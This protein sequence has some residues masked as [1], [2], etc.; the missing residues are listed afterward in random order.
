MKSNIIRITIVLLATLFLAGCNDFLKTSPTDRV[1]DQLVWQNTKYADL[2]I[3]NFYAYF[4]RYGVFG[5]DQFSGNMTEGLTNTLKYGS[6]QPGSK[7]GDSNNYVFYPERISTSQ[8]LLDVW[9]STYERIRRINEFLESMYRL[10]N[11]TVEQKT[12]YEAQA[13]FFRAYCYF[14]LAKRHGG[15]ILYTDINFQK[16]KNRSSAE[17]TWNLISSDLDFAADNLP[18]EWDAQNAGRLTKTMV[19][20]FKSR[21]M[22]Y[23]ERW[24]DAK[25]AADKV[26]SSGKYSLEAEYADAWKGSNAEAIIQVLYNQVSGPNHIFDKSYCP[27][28]DYLASGADENGGCAGP[29]QEMVEAYEAADGSVVDWSPWHQKTT[30]TPPYDQLEPRFHATVLYNGATWKGAVMDITPTGEHGRYMDYRADNYAKGRT[31]TGYYL[32]KLMDE[33]KKNVVQYPSQQTWVELR[34]AEVY[35][36][37]AEAEFRL[38]NNGA[39]LADLN[40]IRARVNL[41]ARTGI[42]GDALFNAIRHERM[43]ELAYE[44]HLFWDMRRWRLADK[45]YNNYRVHGL[46]ITGTAPDYTYEYVDAD[47]QD[48]KFLA[49]TYVFP[50]PDSEITTNTG[51]EQYDEWK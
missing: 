2:Y 13:R 26:V 28:G 15:V 33:T 30:Q 20:A 32:R 27:Y 38:Q 24:Q 4:D 36:N 10:S 29:T 40:V 5:N 14:Q 34:L 48:R 41:P 23:A 46:R 50:I 17:E 11:F 45:E 6:Y 7:A 47:L 51:V 16:S 1:S 18:E 22:L 44:G 39:A 42:A 49:K 25:D 31:V 12:L 8:N 21:A 35:L 43:I 3:N 37:R 19:W 9:N